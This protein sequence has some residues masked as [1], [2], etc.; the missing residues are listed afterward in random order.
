MVSVILIK[1]SEFTVITSSKSE[2]YALYLFPNC[3]DYHTEMLGAWL[4][5]R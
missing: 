1:I 2:L 4:L 3:Y 5:S